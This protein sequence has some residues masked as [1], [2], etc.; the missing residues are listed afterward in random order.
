M[1]LKQPAASTAAG[2][3]CFL[4]SKRR[5]NVFPPTLQ[6][7]PRSRGQSGER[8]CFPQVSILP[9]PSDFF[10]LNSILSSNGL[11]GLSFSPFST[12]SAIELKFKN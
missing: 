9:A 1:W 10:F 7:H 5:G 2:K 11:F 8:S 4:A 12:S 3:D 6:P